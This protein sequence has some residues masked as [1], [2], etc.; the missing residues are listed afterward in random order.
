MN[1]RRAKK[2]TLGSV[3]NNASTIFFNAGTTVI[4]LNT[5]TILSNLATNA[6]S[7]PVIGIKLTVTMMKSKTFQ[8]PLKNLISD[9]SATILIIISTR[10]KTVIAVSRKFSNPKY[11]SER[12]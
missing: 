10:K 11:S 6:V 8:P 3:S 5:L 1:I 12:S 2:P 4:I 9:L 7:P